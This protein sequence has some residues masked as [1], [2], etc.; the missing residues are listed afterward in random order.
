LET[1]LEFTPEHVGSLFATT[2]SARVN[3]QFPTRHGLVRE[4]ARPVYD[5]AALWMN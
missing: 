1:D 5:L 4:T 3:G 2:L